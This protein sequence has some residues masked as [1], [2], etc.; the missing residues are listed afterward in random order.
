MA[1]R[2]RYVPLENGW[3]QIP[4][5]EAPLHKAQQRRARP[6]T[7]CESCTA[8]VWSSRWK[9]HCVCGHQYGLSA[10]KAPAELPPAGVPPAGTEVP[11]DD[12]SAAIF[13]VIRSALQAA[14]ASD[15]TKHQA[16]ERY[17]RTI[18]AGASNTEVPMVKSLTPQ[19]AM[20]AAKD[21]RDEA[22]RQLLQAQQ[23]QKQHQDQLAAAEKK[24]AQL[25]D[26][27][28]GIDQAYEEALR[29]HQHALQQMDEMVG[30]EKD[31]HPAGEAR[32]KGTGMGKG[33]GASGGSLRRDG[34]KPRA[35][36]E[37]RRRPREGRGHGMSVSDTTDGEEDEE[38]PTPGATT[39]REDGDHGRRAGNPRPGDNDIVRQLRVQLAAA[40]AEQAAVQAANKRR[41]LREK[42]QA[43][44]AAEEA[45]VQ[46]EHMHRGAG[47]PIPGGGGS[48][49]AAAAAAAVEGGG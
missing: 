42:E 10:H 15:P 25:L 33:T 34:K 30:A 36:S 37:A 20:R 49:V 9:T 32:E 12:G 28:P 38:V 19:Q 46:A 8:W 29:E 3:S 41:N 35:E 44:Q 14:A 22:H 21:T 7:V 47:V 13:A 39:P 11:E 23:A 40:E 27:K 6:Y 5:R 4:Y 45:A 48:P 31:E 17:L 16:I 24:V 2:R 18:D 1:P 43:A 26:T